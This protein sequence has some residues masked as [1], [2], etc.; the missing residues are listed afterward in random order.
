MK[1]GEVWSVNLDPAIGAE[2]KKTRPCVIVNR[3]SIGILPIK[4][5]VPLTAWQSSFEQA[6]WL[7]PISVSE[8]NGVTKK[9]AAD[10]FQVRSISQKRFVEK[11]GEV[12]AL[13]LGHIDR[14]LRISLD[15]DD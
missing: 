14:G 1:R 9:S 13:E 5:V 8:T 12:S 2:I 4:I 10:T 15:L 7:V 11:L 6:A 3:D